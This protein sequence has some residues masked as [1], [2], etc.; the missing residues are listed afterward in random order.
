VVLAVMDGE[1]VFEFA[2]GAANLETGLMATP[3]TLFPFAS[4][5]KV[6]TATLSW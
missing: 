4:I 6:Y 2:T 1:D 3:D 5:T